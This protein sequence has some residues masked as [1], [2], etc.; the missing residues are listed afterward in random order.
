LQEDCA[1]H[2][3]LH[4]VF[5][6]HARDQAETVAMRMLA[7]STETG[8]SGMACLFEADQVRKLRPLLGMQP[9][10]LRA[11]LESLSI[12]WIEDP[13]N[14]DLRAQRAR[15]RMLR[16]QTAFAATATTALEG[17]ARLRG[18]VRSR[19]D[20]HWQAELAQKVMFSPYGFA[21]LA[22]GPIAPDTLGHLIAAIGGAERP[23]SMTQLQKLAGELRPATLSGVRL[24]R[25]GR[26][27]EG[28]LLLREEA[29]MQPDIDATSGVLW[30][31]RFRLHSLP[32]YAAGRPISV[33]AWGGQARGGR[34][35]LPTAIL[36]TLPVLRA[37]GE[38]IAPP[39]ELFS[40]ARPHIVN[41]PPSPSA[42]APFLPLPRNF[43]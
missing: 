1:A 31:R 34:N 23:P 19:H 17:A 7:G 2:G 8:L 35:E 30:D 21:L 41:E 29:A 33:G 14:T 28:W 40:S 38:V 6:H 12:S 43:E 42:C 15:L 11:T 24:T 10:R 22:P 18:A 4:L 36:R 26:L 13:S 27:G 25:A 20:R 5:G 16:A 9:E 3:I 37:G 32:G 39:W